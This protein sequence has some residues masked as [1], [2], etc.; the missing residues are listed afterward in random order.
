[1]IYVYDNAAAWPRAIWTCEVEELPR[2]QVA[3]RLRR[4]RYDTV[5]HLVDRPVV[6]IRWS[7]G[8]SDDD[9]VSREKRYQLRDGVQRE[10]ST[11]RYVLDASSQNISAILADPLIADTG[12]IDR[13]AARVS[14]DTAAAIDERDMTP[15]TIVGTRPCAAQ[16]Q[17]A[18]IVLDQPDGLVTAETDAPVPGFVFLSEPAYVERKAYVDG[19]AVATRKANLAFIAVPVPAGHHRVELRFVPASFYLGLG[20][21]AITFVSWAGAMYGSHRTVGRSSR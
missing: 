21:S 5:G 2:W 7:D 13:H 1:V 3:L 20:I 6:D 4:G 12:G 19:V 14:P 17:V 18:T 8:I 16:G 11:W 9:R 15:E 10:G